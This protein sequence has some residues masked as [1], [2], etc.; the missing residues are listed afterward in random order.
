MAHEQVFRIKQV[1]GFDGEQVLMFSK[2]AVETTY[3]K[4]ELAARANGDLLA[5]ISKEA[6]HHLGNPLGG[7]LRPD[8]YELDE[9]ELELGEKQ[10]AASSLAAR[11]RT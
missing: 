5:A 11:Q 3:S 7:S 1:T 8:Q 2:A 4:E 10:L 9:R 6:L